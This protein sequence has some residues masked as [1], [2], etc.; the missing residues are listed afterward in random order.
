MTSFSEK[1]GYKPKRTVMQRESMDV[2]LRNGLWN[3]LFLDCLQSLTTKSY[4][5]QL[6]KI[7]SLVIMIIWQDFFKLPLDEIPPECNII[8]KFFKTQFNKYEWYEVY[9]IMQFCSKLI[10]DKDKSEFKS[11]CNRVLERELSAYRFVGNVIAPITTETEIAEI[12]KAIMFDD[13]VATHLKT[14]LDLLSNRESPDYRNSIKE[15]ISAV[16]SICGIIAGKPKTMLGDALA[17]IRKN[18]AIELHPALNAAF[19]KLYGYT[20]DADGIRHALLDETDLKQEDA[21]FMLV[22]CSAFVN[23]LKVKMSRIAK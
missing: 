23:Y 3:V 19:D 6:E 20:S 11:E 22:A 10:D 1:Y 21:I 12:E 14:A 13:P 17:V 5:S 7:Q 9:D 2:L 15:S 16:E 4:F 8:L 18:G